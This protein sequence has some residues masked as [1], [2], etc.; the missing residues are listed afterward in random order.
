MVALINETDRGIMSM[1]N[2]QG[3]PIH[4]LTVLD[5]SKLV[6]DF[7]SGA[8]ILPTHLELEIEPDGNLTPVDIHDGYRVGR[9]LF[10]E[11]MWSPNTKIVADHMTKKVLLYRNYNRA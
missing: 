8:R 1:Q 2:D 3:T 9:Q 11:T 4:N 6:A 5:V 7:E 10:L